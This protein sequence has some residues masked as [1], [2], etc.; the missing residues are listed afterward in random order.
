MEFVGSLVDIADGG[1][2][3]VHSWTVAKSTTY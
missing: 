3:G 1:D 2:V